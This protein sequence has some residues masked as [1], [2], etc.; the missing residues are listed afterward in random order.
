MHSIY[1]A[2]PFSWQWRIKAHAVE[3]QSLGYKITG[4]WLDQ[5]GT[6]TNADNTTIQ[7][8]RTWDECQRLSVRDVSDIFK[9][10]TLI[11]FEPGIPLERNTRIAEFGGALFTGRQCIVIGPEDDD[12]K[13]VISSI[14]VKLKY[15]PEEWYCEEGVG[16]IKPVVQYPTWDLFMEDIL[17]P[18]EVVCCTICGTTKWKTR[19][20]NFEVLPPKRS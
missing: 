6:F 14:F 5:T 9:A 10:D 15:I 12:K 11:L 4:Q 20:T 16:R 3:L 2:G 7:S 8:Q 19:E 17:N 13:E 1:P 18:I